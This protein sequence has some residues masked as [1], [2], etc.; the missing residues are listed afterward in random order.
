MA[1]IALIGRP[2]V[3]KSSLF[4]RIV[5]ERRAIEAIEAVEAGTTRDRLYAP[6]SY[7]GKQFTLVDVAGIGY[8][9]E[10]IDAG[11]AEQIELAKQEADVFIVVFDA[12]AGILHEDE[13]VIASIRRLNKPTL[14]I[15][16]KADN[17]REAEAARSM[18]NVGFIGVFPTSAIHNSGIA[19]VL[20]ELIKHATA[21]PSTG[22]KNEVPVAL[23][24]RPNVGKSTLLN[25]YAGAVR[26]VVSEQPGT[27]R[28]TVDVVIPYKE[29]QFRFV[30][31]AGIRR[32]G[33]IEVG[34]EKFAVMRTVSAVEQA[35]VCVLL[36]DA[37]DGPTAGDT[38]IA[39]LA[40][41]YGKGLILAVNKWDVAKS[42]LRP[43]SGR[44][45][46]S[47]T[48]EILNPKSENSDDELQRIFIAK[49]RAEFAFIPWVP[50]IFISA[51]EGLRTKTLLEQIWKINRVRKQR[52]EQELLNNVKAAAQSGHTH[53][54]L[55]YS[56]TQANGAPL[57]T[58]E[59][60]VN[61]PSTWHFSHLRYIENIIR[62]ADAYS[63]TPI[64]I[65]LVA[66]SKS[67]T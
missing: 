8:G 39:G 57:P 42:D 21:L 2:N 60:T 1:T 65:Q 9:K 51:K 58:F 22:P 64:K 55:I 5:G 43:R 7:R 31:T 34:V 6:V 4:N 33:K 59:V 44:P 35:D 16:N 10:G 12:Q 63:G 66:Y 17:M 13:Q 52:I 62:E 3:G 26:S 20:D 61:R 49:L 24:G 36:I 47:R 32:S 40:L 11:V 41:E 56:L 38:H 28:D 50:V 29:Q 15:A 19:D 67:Q 27:T 46:P 14:L 30:D 25:H 53:L 48:G 45:E 54:P 37:V 18:N 23:I